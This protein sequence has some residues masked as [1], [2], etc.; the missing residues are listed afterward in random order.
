MATNSKEIL[1]IK[2]KTY[3]TFSWDEKYLAILMLPLLILLQ[4]R[5][6][7]SVFKQKTLFLIT[8]LTQTSLQC[9]YMHSSYLKNIKKKL[10]LMHSFLTKIKPGDNLV[11]KNLENVSK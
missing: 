5:K 9:I 2:Q 11:D 3:K 4:D 7:F 1:L 10:I 6:Q 8:K